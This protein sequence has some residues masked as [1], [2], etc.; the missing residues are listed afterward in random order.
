MVT[1]KNQT[2]Q[3]KIKFMETSLTNYLSPS[4]CFYLSIS[5]NSG[6]NT[7]LTVIYDFPVTL[8]LHYWSPE[9]SNLRYLSFTPII[10]HPF[11]KKIPTI[12]GHVCYMRTQKFLPPF[13]AS[14]TLS[15]Q[16]FHRTKQSLCSFIISLRTFV[17]LL[18]W[19]KPVNNL[20]T[21]IRWCGYNKR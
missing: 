18:L 12:Q 5:N 4:L 1:N 19:G 6:I 3:T 8:L 15:F 9:A 11:L 13:E 20:L 21:P 14:V 10:F 17:Y 7:K 16:L 2:F